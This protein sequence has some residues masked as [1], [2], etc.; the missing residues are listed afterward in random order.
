MRWQEKHIYT[1]QKYK[2][3]STGGT[4]IYA[5]NNGDRKMLGIYAVITTYVPVPLHG[6]PQI[7]IQRAIVR[8]TSQNSRTSPDIIQKVHH[9]PDICRSLTWTLTNPS[10]RQAT[11]WRDLTD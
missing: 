6:V 9:L 4:E 10:L 7:I 11:A 1:W 8:E 2:T 3:F 5:L